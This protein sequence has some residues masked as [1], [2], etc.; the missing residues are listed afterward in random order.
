MGDTAAGPIET[1]QRRERLLAMKIDIA[2]RRHPVDDQVANQ[3]QCDSW[4]AQIR[5]LTGVASADS[6]R[7]PS[8]S[9]SSVGWRASH[10]RGGRE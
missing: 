6:S 7:A 4:D 8:T 9:T 5:P 2:A 1:L 10:T 3:R